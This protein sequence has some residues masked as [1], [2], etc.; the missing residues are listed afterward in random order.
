MTIV[1]DASSGVN[2]LKASL[3]DAT[4]GVIYDRHMFI[5]QVTGCSVKYETSF[6]H[7]DM[8]LKDMASIKNLDFVSP[9]RFEKKCSYFMQRQY[10]VCSLHRYLRE[11]DC[12]RQINLQEN[13][14]Q[15]N[16]S[17]SSGHEQGGQYWPEK[18]SELTRQVDQVIWCGPF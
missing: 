1:N 9:T 4:R 11:V 7:W 15:H 3:N 17:A 12:W 14:P 16:M 6:W 5:V 18:A 13:P 8:C 2:K 10:W